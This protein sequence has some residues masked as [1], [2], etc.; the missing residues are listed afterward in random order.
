MFLPVVGPIMD[1]EF[2]ARG[3]GV[4]RPDVH[5][6][7]VPVATNLDVSPLN[8]PVVNP[9]SPAVRVCRIGVYDYRELSGACQGLVFVQ[10]R[11]YIREVLTRCV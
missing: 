11:P 7:R 5:F 6:V 3:D 10:V 9:A 2:C 1:R 8:E 4:Q